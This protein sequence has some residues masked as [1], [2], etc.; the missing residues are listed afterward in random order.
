MSERDR[1]DEYDAPEFELGGDDGDAIKNR[2]AAGA[3]FAESTQ[4]LDLD[5]KGTSAATDFLGIEGDVRTDEVPAPIGAGLDTSGTAGLPADSW[6]HGIEDREEEALQQAQAAAEATETETRS[7]DHARLEG[8]RERVSGTGVGFP[9]KKVLAACVVLALA[10]G[11]AWY[12][13][14]L[15]DQRAQT[16]PVEVATQPTPGR[17]NTK[18]PAASTKPAPTVVGTQPE[19]EPPTNSDPTDPTA[20]VPLDPAA[21]PEAGSTDPVPTSEPVAVTPT[22]QFPDS[23]NTEPVSITATHPEP[24]TVDPNP[25]SLPTQVRALPES[26]NPIPGALRRATEAD[27]ANIWREQAVPLNAIAGDRRLRTVNV[28]QVRVML[29]SGEY[30]EGALYAVGENRVWLDLDLGRISFEGTTVREITRIAAPASAVG[31][32]KKGPDLS[33]LPHVEARLP[34]GWMSGR[35]VGREGNTV[36][37]VTDDG[38]R[39]VIETDEVRPIT[40]RKTR[41]VGTVEKLGG[42]TGKPAGEPKK[43]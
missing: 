35:L 3:A 39:M 40:A 9:L 41:V 4:E 26:T 8:I 23:T 15:R 2:P 29:D 27:F 12:W 19:V 42:F 25:V 7:N 30:F 18:K 13:K 14:K 36:T 28:G 21:G 5:W 43:P 1:N 31:A 20:V 24:S 10:A 16:T 11:G 32:A 38:I 22:I 33:G 17:P 37:L 6:L 34:G